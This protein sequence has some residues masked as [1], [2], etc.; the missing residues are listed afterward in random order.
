MSDISSQ[1]ANTLKKLSEVESQQLEATTGAVGKGFGGFIRDII[2]GA[3]KEAPKPKVEPKLEPGIGG[4]ADDSIRPGE[5]IEPS[6]NTLPELKNLVDGVKLAAVKNKMYIPASALKKGLDEG[7][8]VMQ[9]AME[10]YPEKF[11]QVQKDPSKFKKFLEF[12]QGFFAGAEEKSKSPDPKVK[13]RWLL[14]ALV[15]VAAALRYC[16]VQVSDAEAEKEK[17]LSGTSSEAGMA[18]PAEEATK[19]P[20]DE[21]PW[22]YLGINP[23]AFEGHSIEKTTM[24]GK[25]ISDDW[26]VKS[27]AG[28]NSGTISDPAIKEKIN[29][30]L[31]MTPEQRKELKANENRSPVE[32]WPEMPSMAPVEKPVVEPEPDIVIQKA[33]E[34]KPAASAPTKKKEKKGTQSDW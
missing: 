23:K 22:K 26:I 7:K 18:K 2:K 24:F 6:F 12:W 30:L 28:R 33:K 21:I 8:S 15:A 9:I 32:L 25:A 29:K 19:I 27:P 34:P 10:L 17:A 4:K 31:Q 20:A 16:G 5:K 3:E 14:L 1:I 13:K 11:A